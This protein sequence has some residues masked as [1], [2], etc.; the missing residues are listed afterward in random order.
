MSESFSASRSTAL[1]FDEAG[2]P[3]TNGLIENL[4]RTGYTNLATYY[5]GLYCPG[6]TY[7]PVSGTVAAKSNNTLLEEQ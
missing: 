1:G 7:D 2:A 4:H 6:F 3:I 5:V